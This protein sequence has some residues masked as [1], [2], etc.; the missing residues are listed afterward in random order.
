ML[1]NIFA[2]LLD[3]KRCFIAS[4][5]YLSR[6]FPSNYVSD[7]L[8]LL[9]LVFSSL[10]TPVILGLDSIHCLF[11]LVFL[12]FFIFLLHTRSHI[13]YI[14]YINDLIFTVLILF[15][16]FLVGHPSL[17]LSCFFHISLFSP[18]DF[19]PRKSLLPA[20][21]IP[22]RFP[23]SLFPVANNCQIYDLFLSPFC[24]NCKIFSKAFLLTP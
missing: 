18:C 12:L 20:T 21:E 23:K 9:T 19:Q 1:L 17:P 11:S 3:V 13:M 7:F 24:L 22:T 8:S 14:F 15:L 2:I 5:N 16:G 6:Y 4:R 10:E